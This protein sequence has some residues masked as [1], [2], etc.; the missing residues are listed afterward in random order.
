MAAG[1]TVENVEELKHDAKSVKRL[2]PKDDDTL[3]FRH[4]EEADASE[5]APKQEPKQR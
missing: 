3:D 4:D 2:T 5:P 1:I